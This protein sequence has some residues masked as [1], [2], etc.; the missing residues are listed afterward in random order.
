MEA[1]EVL[2]P[3]A[4]VG[5]LVF[6]VAGMLGTGLALTF[7]AITGPLR[8]ARLVA[9]LLAVNFVVVPAAGLL[10]VTVLPV[11]DASR[12]S[13]LLVAC[14]AGA[15]FLAPLARLA[16]GDTPT[17]VGSMVLLMVVTVGY[18]PVVVPWL[19]PDA[20]VSPGEIA[21]SLIWLM[22]L[23][24]VAGLL[25]HARYA[26][27]AGR[28]APT[29]QRLSTTGLALGLAAAL[30]AGWRDLLGVVGTWMFL[31]VALLILAG[32]GAGAVSGPG[33]PGSERRVLELGAAQRNIAAAIV[34][35]GSLGPDV[36]VRTLAAA[37]VMPVVLILLAAE[38]G[39]RRS[40]APVGE[41]A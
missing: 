6:V 9:G 21:G 16:G 37:V 24:L 26:D 13:L 25:V 12:T 40:S 17:A 20:A 38:L 1:A 28:W 19:V 5:M 35:A 34:I 7:G 27:H 23:P 39:R 31:G 33:R 22:I 30:L 2:I 14:V 15:P 32:L 29:M 36:V 11:D 8:D 3:L 4:R 18:A 10:V 41:D